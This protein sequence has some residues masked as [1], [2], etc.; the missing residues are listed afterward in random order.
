MAPDIEQ[1]DFF[2][3]DVQEQGDA[4]GVGDADSVESFQ[5]A[6]ERMQAKP[7]FQWV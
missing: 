2:L 4:V 1:C 5:L 6:F 3:L 7:W